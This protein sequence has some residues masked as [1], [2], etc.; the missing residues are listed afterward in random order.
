M[1]GP[2]VLI[3]ESKIKNDKPEFA[4]PENRYAKEIEIP[5]VTENTNIF[6]RLKPFF[7]LF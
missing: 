2:A 6:P 4:L 5:K 3:I 1:L 7:S